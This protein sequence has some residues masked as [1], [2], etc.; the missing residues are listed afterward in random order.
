MNNQITSD[1]IHSFFSLVFHKD[2][3]KIN[4]KDKSYNESLSSIIA[5][6]HEG[7]FIVSNEHFEK[8]KDED[9]CYHTQFVIL[10]NFI[11][12]GI[13]YNKIYILWNEDAFN[14]NDK[15]C[16]D[17]FISRV[18]NTLK[19]RYNIDVNDIFKQSITATHDSILTNINK[20]R[21]DTTYSNIS[22]FSNDYKMNY[23]SKIDEAYANMIDLAEK[24]RIAKD[25]YNNV[26]LLNQ[27]E[28]LA[29][30][31][32]VKDLYEFFNRCH[33]LK[34]FS[35]LKKDDYYRVVLLTNF[36][37]IEYTVGEEVALAMTDK[38]NG[39]KYN[40]SQEYKDIFKDA[41]TDRNNYIM[42]IE[43][44]EITYILKIDKPIQYQINYSYN[45]SFIN[46]H[47]RRFT[48]YG[49]FA[50]SLTEAVSNRNLIQLTSILLQ[51]L[52]TI[53]LNDYAGQL[54]ANETALLIDNK[55]T[56]EKVKLSSLNI[57]NVIS[58]KPMSTYTN[59]F[60]ALND[61]I[62]IIKED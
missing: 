27:K 28:T 55:N 41:L 32:I 46:V 49:G 54:W 47:H 29:E 62:A 52:Q 26:L 57:Y 51:Y 39:S 60:L 56:H 19:D 4:L 9:A 37:P 38:P 12:L 8:L 1:T 3:E 20:F 5:H 15:D 6:N 11:M 10:T 18:M 34:G 44:V 22:N 31:N 17:L 48:C 43:P 40:A 30:N 7:F 59:G 42:L 24:L 50:P 13:R 14:I 33:L 16:L 36:L 25:H 35:V 53:N 58:E 61:N 45:Q 23:K 21:L 2:I